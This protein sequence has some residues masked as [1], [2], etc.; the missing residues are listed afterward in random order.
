MCCTHMIK[1]TQFAMTL[2]SAIQENQENMGSH[3]TACN[4]DKLA[5]ALYDTLIY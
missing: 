5:G 4:D 3:C 2:A 1:V